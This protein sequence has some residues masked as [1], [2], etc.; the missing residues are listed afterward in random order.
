MYCTTEVLFMRILDSN[1]DISI[2]DVVL[3]LKAEEAKE[4][5]NSI[6]LLIEAN[7]YSNHAHIDDA[8]HEHAIT[9]V[10]YDEHQLDSLS[11]R[12]KKIILEDN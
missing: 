11:E 8:S 4:F 2:K 6:G 12:S 3:Y 1:N 9:V 5:Y 10:L 7:D